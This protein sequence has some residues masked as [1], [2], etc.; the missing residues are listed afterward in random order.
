M[1]EVPAT[2]AATGA[3]STNTGSASS[4]QA[5]EAVETPKTVSYEEFQAL[6]AQNDSLWKKFREANQTKQPNSEEAEPKTAKEDIARLRTELKL[7]QEK[8]E[9]KVRDLAL[10]DAIVS[11][12]IDSDSVQ[13]FMDH[14]KAQH[15]AQIKVDDDNV[16]YEDP[17]TTVRQPISEFVASLLRGPK[18]DKFR[19]PVQTAGSKTL[20]SS[21]AQPG[22][23]LPFG[24]LSPEEQQKLIANGTAAA[25]VAEELGLK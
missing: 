25:Y 19:A 13:I 10:K 21:S 18:G 22:Q 1:A 16:L 14:V 2:P 3:A 4:P 15:G 23:R 8:A 24:Q 12:G 7:S 17:L 20:R 5:S 9:R 11:A 6:K